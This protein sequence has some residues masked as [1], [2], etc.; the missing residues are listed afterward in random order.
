MGRGSEQCPRSPQAFYR[1]CEGERIPRRLELVGEGAGKTLARALRC[2]RATIPRPPL[3]GIQYV[4]WRWADPEPCS[5]G[6][7]TVATGRLG[8]YAR[9]PILTLCRRRFHTR[10]L[11]A[12]CPG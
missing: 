11:G 7:G 12:Q 6:W 3:G 4:Q 10:T 1:I 9:L 2:T 5:P 8:N